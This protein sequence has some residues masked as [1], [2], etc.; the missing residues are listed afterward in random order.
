M[1]RFEWQLHGID[2]AGYGPRLGPL[3]QACASLPQHEETIIDFDDWE[4]V[5]AAIAAAGPRLRAVPALAQVPI[6]DSK[7][8]FAAARRQG[9]RAGSGP[10][11][12]VESVSAISGSQLGAAALWRALMAVGGAADGHWPSWLQVEE[13]LHP[14]QEHPSAGLEREILASA[15]SASSS[16]MLPAAGRLAVHAIC[17]Y[18]GQFNDWAGSKNKAEINWELTRRLVRRQLAKSTSPVGGPTAGTGSRPKP[19]VW[20]LDRQGGRRRYGG[21]LSELFAPAYVQIVMETAPLCVYRVR[22]AAVDG[23]VTVKVEGESWSVG[24]ALASMAAKALRE[25]AMAR[26]NRYFCSRFPALQP[27]AGYPVD[28]ERW[29]A[30]VSQDPAEAQQPWERV[31]RCK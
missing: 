28:A 2:E 1:S 19:T 14:V 6:G 27:T 20:T 16:S 21:L 30:A 17:L 5:G 18:P 11:S 25:A 13:E 12:G 10:V 8:L 29:R 24:T 31:W 3:V 9:L 4:T 26:L 7:Q 22:G 15:A 23:W